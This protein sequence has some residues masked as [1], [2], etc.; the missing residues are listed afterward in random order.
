MCVDFAYSSFEEDIRRELIAAKGETRSAL[1]RILEKVVARRTALDRFT[2]TVA[3]RAA[4]G[5]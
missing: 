5:V 3:P 2:Q 1:N 4:S